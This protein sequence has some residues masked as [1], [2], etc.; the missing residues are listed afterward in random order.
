MG[1]EVLGN[2]STESIESLISCLVNFNQKC[3][4]L[5][6][7]LPGP[8][9]R[10]LKKKYPSCT[11]VNT[12]KRRKKKLSPLIFPGTTTQRD[13]KLNDVIDNHE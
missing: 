6:F 1:G 12:T 13:V 7:I 10:R 5:S 11:D 3:H 4:A 9:S 8:H 2:I